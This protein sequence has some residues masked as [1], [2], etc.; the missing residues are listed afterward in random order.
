MGKVSKLYLLWAI[1]QGLI[2]NI[3][4]GVPHFKK[5]VTLKMYIF[6]RL[7]IAKAIMPPFNKYFKLWLRRFSLGPPISGAPQSYMH[8][9]CNPFGVAGGV[10]I[11]L[12]ISIGCFMS[13][14]SAIKG[15]PVF[16]A[17]HRRPTLKHIL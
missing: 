4:A 17:E 5:G 10:H 9:P 15:P 16:Y 6:K 3:L 12:V 1:N 11:R 2:V 8:P 13:Y 14:G 7:F